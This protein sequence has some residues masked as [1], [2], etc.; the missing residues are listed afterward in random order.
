MPSL[1]GEQAALTQMT[2][3]RALLLSGRRRSLREIAFR[4]LTPRS[5]HL[6]ATGLILLAATGLTERVV[7][8]DAS[9]ELSRVDWLMFAAVAMCHLV[10][11]YSSKCWITSA[12][13]A[14][15][16]LG[17]TVA[18]VGLAGL[19]LRLSGI[20]GSITAFAT[21]SWPTACAVVAAGVAMLGVN[22]SLAAFRDWAY[23]STPVQVALS[24]QFRGH[25]AA[26]GALL[27]LAPI[28]VIG[29]SFNVVLVPLLTAT[30]IFIFRSTRQG[31]DPAHEAQ[32]DP[33][34]GLLNSRSFATTS[35][36][37]TGNASFA[38]ARR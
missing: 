35:T 18:T 13:V 4:T 31:F 9:F 8:L 23:R 27:S 26:D 19:I 6:A 22:A 1:R 11:E 10:G 38:L 33:L 20:N 5:A 17:S 34:T 37:S 2:G 12:L 24:R 30:S 7:R 32:H 36:R 25:I 3:R 21:I 16:R 15:S 28:W 29:A 14:L